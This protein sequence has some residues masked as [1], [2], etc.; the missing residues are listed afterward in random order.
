[1][2]AE[3][4]VMPGYDAISADKTDSIPE[5]TQIGLGI[6]NCLSRILSI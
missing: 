3:S 2:I 5:I 1:M 4:A 6:T